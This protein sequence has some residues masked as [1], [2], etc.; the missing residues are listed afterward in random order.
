MPR[1][2]S[3]ICSRGSTEH[4]PALTPPRS[5]A[6]PAGADRADHGALG[7]A[8]DVGLEAALLDAFDHVLDLLLS[9][10]RTHINDHVGT[11]SWRFRATKKPA[12]PV[13]GA[14]LVEACCGFAVQLTIESPAIAPLP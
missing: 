7:A 8:N 5:A 13:R 4:R 2:V 12:S 14:G 6:R 11:A 10:F 3:K 9:R 1:A